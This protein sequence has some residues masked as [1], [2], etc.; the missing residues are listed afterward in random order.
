MVLDRSTWTDEFRKRLRDY[1]K[2]RNALRELTQKG[3]LEGSLLD[4]LY[5][6]TI[7][8]ALVFKKR[9][10]AR[11]LALGGVRSVARRLESASKQM[12]DTLDL[13]MME[14]WDLTRMLR[15]R[16]IF[17]M[18]AGHTSAVCGSDFP[19]FAVGLPDKLRSY[20]QQLRWLRSQLQ[21][22]I[23]TRRVQHSIYLAELA[24]YI[25][26]VTR[27]PPSWTLIEHL[28]SA[29]Q[30]ASWPQKDIDPTLLSKNFKSFVR[31]NSDLYQEIQDQMT[32]YLSACSQVPEGKI[33]PSIGTWK[34]ERKASHQ[35]R[36]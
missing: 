35:P 12:Q 20:S 32:E 4:L 22:E 21:R 25:E 24:T 33:P 36:R 34:V 3:C 30:P 1:E 10:R 2:P 6:Y 29:A 18:P 23:S 15:E 27:T 16:A 8:P 31:R 26:A 7:S 17:K 11:A 28:V 5:A 13:R 9:A 14:G 19:D